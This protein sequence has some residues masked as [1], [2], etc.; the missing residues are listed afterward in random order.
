MERTR[1]RRSRVVL[2]LAM[3]AVLWISSQRA[4][5][6][7]APGASAHLA[8]HSVQQ[9]L[10]LTAAFGDANLDGQI[11]GRVTVDE[12]SWTEGDWN[13]DMFDILSFQHGLAASA[14]GGAAT[15]QDIVVTKEV[16]RSTPKLAEA[17]AEGRVFPKVGVDFTTS[18]GDAGSLPYLRYELTNVTATSHDIGADPDDRPTEEVAFNF[19][20]IKV[21]YTEYDDSGAAKGETEFSW[22]VE[23]GKP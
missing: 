18:Y 6:G 19:E 5:D 2:V 7:F 12:A 21:T 8:N 23:E 11:R 13:G 22:K 4:I 16:D 1:N 3:M 15:L 17:V 10:P 20:E 14:D 9:M